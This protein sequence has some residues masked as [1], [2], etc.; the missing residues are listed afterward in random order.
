MGGSLIPIP[1]IGMGMVDVT[2]S[3][4]VVLLEDFAATCV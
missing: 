1:F 4:I 3:R 2:Q